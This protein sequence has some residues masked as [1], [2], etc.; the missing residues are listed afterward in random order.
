MTNPHFKVEGDHLGFRV[1]LKGVPKHV[2][3]QIH[4]RELKGLDHAKLHRLMQCH[5]EVAIAEALPHLKVPG[6]KEVLK[7]MRKWSDRSA[8]LYYGRAAKSSWEP[9]T[10][11]VDIGT[12][13]Q[14]LPF[15]DGRDH[16]VI[17]HWFFDQSELVLGDK[18][19]Q[20]VQK[21]DWPGETEEVACVPAT[22][23]VL[24][25]RFRVKDVIEKAHHAILGEHE[26]KISNAFYEV[27]ERH[28]AQGQLE[29]V[30]TYQSYEMARKVWE[31]AKK[32]AQQQCYWEENHEARG[33][34]N[35]VN[36]FTW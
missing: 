4:C 7:R 6:T 31:L 9:K 20:N 26:R 29:L 13:S 12:T 28:G 2:D 24:W 3:V 5:T 23:N 34:G 25:I 22:S 30:P 21:L 18:K 35:Q 10:A 15:Y 33:F 19:D 27:A 11:V 8:E 36:L 32:V 14:P 17:A 1:D 16:I